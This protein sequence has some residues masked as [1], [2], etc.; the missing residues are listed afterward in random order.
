MAVIFGYLLQQFL[1]ELVVLRFLLHAG[2]IAGEGGLSI[3]IQ[4]ITHEYFACAADS[5]SS[6]R[7]GICNVIV[8][9]V[10]TIIP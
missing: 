5:A 6:V 3:S 10:N 2:T 8:G 1:L 7:D 4:S 9:I